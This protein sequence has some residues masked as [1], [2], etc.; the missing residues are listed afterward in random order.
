MVVVH[1]VAKG[2]GEKVLN[3]FLTKDPRIDCE[4]RGEVLEVLD[5]FLGLFKRQF[6][7]VQHVPKILQRSKLLRTILGL[8]GIFPDQALIL[9]WEAHVWW[10]VN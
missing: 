7:I 10:K 2:Y 6:I 3:V 4:Q 5:Y 1:Q 8:L 9:A